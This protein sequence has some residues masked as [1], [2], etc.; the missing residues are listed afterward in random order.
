MNKILPT[1]LVKN[2][3]RF[4]RAVLRPLIKV[5]GVALVVDNGST[6]RT[7]EFATSVSNIIF[8]SIDTPPEKFFEARQ[9][10]TDVARELGYTHTLLVD[11]DELYSEEGARIVRDVPMVMDGATGFVKMNTIDYD[12]ATDTYWI[13]DD[14]FSRHAVS[15]TDVTW[16]GAYP[17]DVPSSYA[18]PSNYFYY[19]LTERVPRH[20]LHLHRLNRSSG[21]QN[22]ELRTKKQFQYGLQN[23]DIPRLEI[24]K[25]SSILLD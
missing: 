13:L 1:L 10:M 15:R 8:R 23:L 19:P 22:V 14:G 11:G 17:F 2:E 5:F 25:E 18:K 6:D 3:E 9:F 12:S 7:F 20:A 4:I 21:D 24:W 16:T